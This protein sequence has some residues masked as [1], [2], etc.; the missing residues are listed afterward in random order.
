[1]GVLFS[2]LQAAYR[3]L[4]AAL[5]LLRDLSTEFNRALDRASQPPGLPTPT[6][7]ESYWLND[8]P[9]PELVN[10]CSPTLPDV[11]DVVII[12][13]GIA[14]AAIARS[15]LSEG[16]PSVKRNV[17]V[18]EARQLCS[19]ATGRNGGHIKVAAYEAFARLS[20]IF[21]KERAAALVRFQ[22]R[23]VEELVHL[24]RREGFDVAE[25]REVETADLFLDSNTFS[26]A[27]DDVK[28]MQKWLPE[29]QV[30]IWDKDQAQQVRLN[31][32]LRL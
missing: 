17:V 22:S 2:T 23:H 16:S 18:L 28:E 3:S 20:K 31:Y 24:C 9:F 14:G 7:T 1:M 15:L 26:K 6:P 5:V 4:S 12:G 29:I 13:S 32:Y 11:A 10:T 8:P 21:T 25:A 27:I 19:G 30:N